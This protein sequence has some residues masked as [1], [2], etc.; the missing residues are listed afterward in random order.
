MKALSLF[1]EKISETPPDQKTT[2]KWKVFIF[3]FSFNFFV[4]FLVY[5][6]A[7]LI[8]FAHHDQYRYFNKE[9]N[10]QHL[11]CHADYQYSVLYALGRP[12][13][14]E[15]E[16]LAFK[17]TN[18]IED[19][20]SLRLG[21]LLI[22]AISTTLLG[23]WL[24]SLHL[25]ALT[26]FFLSTSIFTLPGPQF[27]IILGN[28]PNAFTL[29][30]TI[31]SYFI[32]SSSLI[33]AS[34]I[35]ENFTKNF[36]W[37]FFS[38]ALLLTALFTY[39]AMTLY[40]FVPTLSWILFSRHSTPKNLIFIIVRDISFFSTAACVYLFIRKQFIVPQFTETLAN[41]PPS[42][43]FAIDINLIIQKLIFFFKNVV[44]MIF[45]YWNI[46]TLPWLGTLL[47]F[48]FFSFIIVSS[49][50][51]MTDTEPQSAYWPKTINLLK[52]LLIIAIFIGTF[53]FWFLIGMEFVLFRILFV[54]TAI[55][56]LLGFW[57][58]NRCLELLSFRN[59]SYFI[60]L[61]LFMAGCVFANINTNR[62]ALN[63]YKE[64][65]LI[66]AEILSHL[67][68]DISLSRIHFV[69]PKDIQFGFNG[70][71]SLTDEFNRNSSDY[72]WNI[73]DMALLALREINFKSQKFSIFQ[74]ANQPQED[75]LAKAPNDKILITTSESN[76]TIHP[77]PNMIIIDLNKLKSGKLA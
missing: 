37:I 39:T 17:F 40:F 66:K 75:C 55:A 74:C 54:P 58:L 9:I 24:Y 51:Q 32:F 16:C 1:F 72:W 65:N 10:N 42:Y 8:P 76:A 71:P 77:S 29:T 68:S 4:L 31:L 2:P 67:D 56:L 36:L 73:P 59:S 3:L 46:Y 53:S 49:Y 28:I 7:I 45:N 38:F 27:L 63:S 15:L 50:F 69:R 48:L 62:N 64:L 13:V 34:K 26:S 57:C 61:I 5:S 70:L 30:L 6:P 44:P 41:V 23:L 35:K 33:H 11:P 22:M 60:G 20:S 18:K 21:S 25:P 12:M 43:K 19:L 47:A 14:A 52:P